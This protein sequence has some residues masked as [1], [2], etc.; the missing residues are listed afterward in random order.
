MLR[1]QRLSR[2]GHSDARERFPRS[3]SRGRS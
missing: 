3:R 1:G 2:A